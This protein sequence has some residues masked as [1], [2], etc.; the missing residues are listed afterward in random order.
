MRRIHIILPTMP[1]ATKAIT[2]ATGMQ[3]T[4]TSFMVVLPSLA[5]TVKVTSSPWLLWDPTIIVMSCVPSGR[6]FGTVNLTAC[7]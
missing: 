1:A 6:S 7:V 2:H 5:L 4:R 3:M